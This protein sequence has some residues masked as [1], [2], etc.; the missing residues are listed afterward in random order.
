MTT[1]LSLT[2]PFN[3]RSDLDVLIG[4]PGG[5]A[6]SVDTNDPNNGGLIEARVVLT[7]QSLNDLGPQI[8]AVIFAD[9]ACT[10]EGWLY[11]LKI[12][13]WIRIFT[14]AIATAYIGVSIGS[15]LII[16]SIPDGWPFFL[17]VSANGGN[18]M[19]AGIFFH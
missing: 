19:V 12:D 4:T 18:A 16:A 10:L 15:G 17:R 1:P 3:N 5:A 6:I 2:A 9:A 8:N 13:K 14:Q 7:E 11:S